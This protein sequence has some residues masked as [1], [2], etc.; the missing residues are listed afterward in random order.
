MRLLTSLL[1]ATALVAA[2]CGGT[3]ARV[4]TGA[5]D[6]VP[7]TAPVFIAVDS[8]PHSAEWR[9]LDMLA[10]K[11]P[12]KQQAVDRLKR[13]IRQESGIEWNRDVV[14]A[15][16]DEVDFVWL[17]FANDGDNFVVLT[18]PK[19]EA[20]LRRFVEKAN[21][22]E[23]D[24][25]DRAHFEK[26]HD[27]YVLGEQASIE[28]F[29]RESETAARSLSDE[30]AFRQSME[31]L[32]GDS[33]VRAYI[34]GDAVMDAIRSYGGP[35]V[36][37]YVDKLGK[38]DWLAFR[39]G[40]RS[41]GIG[42]DAIV[43][44]RP[45]ELFKDAATAKGFEPELT[46][47]IP[48]NALLYFTFHGVEGMFDSVKANDLFNTPDTRQFRDVFDELDKLLQ[49]EN[50][51]YLR[52]GGKR[53]NRVPFEVPE[54]TLVTSPPDEDGAA[55]VDGLLHRKLNVVPALQ[56][57]DGVN[58]HRIDEGGLGL[59]YGNVDG[60]LVLT[61][62]AAGIRGFNHPGETLAQSDK[63]RSM[64]SASGLPGKVPG[65]FYVDIKSTIPFGEKLARTRIPESIRRNL[66][67]LSSV[68]EYAA[69]R[70]A[71]VKV[72]FFLLLK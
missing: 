16:G 4:A 38:L 43:H 55:T 26:F 63:Y 70:S 48:A 39:T 50:A 44:G 34:N 58:V 46:D 37:R 19:D 42:F 11:F 52:P 3:T 13:E 57:I 24:P 65:I 29:K 14:P 28:R 40:A 35:D 25:A 62:T 17:D 54:I 45:G 60:R 15:L 69:T 8:N 51:V 9:K 49:G 5:S 12:D 59:Y 41:D 2:G 18:Q 68:V 47:H 56:T 27:W 21:T 64:K 6:V 61:D 22:T 20:A 31:R 33:V 10:S 32:G 30:S 53:V 67:P 72:S 36:E 7:S 23:R 1:A 66:K 71:E